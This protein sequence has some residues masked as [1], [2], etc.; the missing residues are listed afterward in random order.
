MY[1]LA[2]SAQ[3]SGQARAVMTCAFDRPHTRARRM[4]LC[5]ANG[6]GIALSVCRYRSLRDQGTRRRDDNREHVLIAM[7]VDTD[8]V[9]QFV[10]KHPDRSSVRR[11]R[12][13]GLEQGNRAAGL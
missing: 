2:A 13:A 9:I 7:G 4:P 1:D 12:Y 10:C 11:V 5:K 6:L 3:T 8:D